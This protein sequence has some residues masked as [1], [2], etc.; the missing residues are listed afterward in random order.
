MLQKGGL[1]HDT[2]TFRLSEQEYPRKHQCV[3]I[4]RGATR[5]TNRGERE[6]LFPLFH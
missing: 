2:S 1:R 4:L 3:A 6:Y 5:C